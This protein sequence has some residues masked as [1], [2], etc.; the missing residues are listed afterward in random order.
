MNRNNSKNVIIIAFGEVVLSRLQMIKDEY[1]K[2]ITE[3][4]PPG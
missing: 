1:R 3:I 4:I 2:K